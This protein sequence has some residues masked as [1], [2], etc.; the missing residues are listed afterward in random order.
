MDDTLLIEN[1]IEIEQPIGIFLVAKMKASALLA[2]SS[3]EERYYNKELEEYIGIQRPLKRDKIKSLQKF[4]NTNDATFP[5]TIIGTLDTD[6]YNYNS[7]EKKLTI[8]QSKDAFKI[9]DGQHRLMAFEEQSVAASFD[10]LVVFF[11]DV[12]L[13][14]QAYIFS[15]INTTQSKLDPSLVQDLSE[16]SDITTPEKIV[17]SI[18]KI[19]NKRN[20]SPWYKMIKLLGK[21]DISSSNAIISQYSFNRSILNYMYDKNNTAEIRNIL[22]E[23]KN[24]RINLNKLDINKN[25]FIFWDFYVNSEEGTLYL[26]LNAYFDAL[27]EVFSSEWCS[28]ESILC[29]TT[30]Y[31]AFM[32]L[33]KN[34]YLFADRNIVD[35]K[36]KD[37]YTSVLSKKIVSSIDLKDSSYR[38]GAAGATNLYTKLSELF[39]SK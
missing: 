38:L 31:D 12:D 3:K 11:L 23:S 34:F 32:K 14:D 28:Q 25:K 33:F 9:I 26:I 5:N 1:I 37:F 19:F 18:A 20:D 35:L 24:K 13:S 22:K 7:T 29:K 21:K 36:T 17:H 15:I 27:K 39:N 4:I 8:K 30:G 2:I 6:F 16:L 10:L